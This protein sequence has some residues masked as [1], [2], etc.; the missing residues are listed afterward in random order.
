[1]QVPEATPIDRGL[2]TRKLTGPLGA[3]VDAVAVNRTISSPS[4]EGFVIVTSGESENA[5]APGAKPKPT[6]AIAVGTP[7]VSWDEPLKP[8]TE[9]RI[10]AT[11]TVSECESVSAAS[12]F[13]ARV[14]NWISWPSALS[15]GF[16]EAPFAGCPAAVTDARCVR[17]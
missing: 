9:G 15:H 14:S 5:T 13:V 11:T 8:T 2:T 4:V 12:R 6:A 7:G 10:A 1:M 17:W 16:V 3:V